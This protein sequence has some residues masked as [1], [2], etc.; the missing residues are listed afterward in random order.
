MSGV[1]TSTSNSTESLSS[2]AI[3]SS[4]PTISAPAASAAVAASPLATA[5]TRGVL[6]V[7]CGKRQSAAHLLV[8]LFRVD[9]QNNRHI[10]CF[11]ELR[12]GGALYQPNCFINRQHP[13]FTE[14]LGQRAI[15]FSVFLRHIHPFGVMSDG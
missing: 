7:P 15:S 8:A 11:V 3:R 9:A 10:D 13:A 12:V 14:L 4:A 1:A 2:C 6:P 5:T